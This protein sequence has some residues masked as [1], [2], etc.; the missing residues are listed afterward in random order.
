MSDAHTQSS[1]CCG[2]VPVCRAALG[3]ALLL[4]VV[5]FAY[6][7]HRPEPLG[8]GVRTNEQRE[9]NLRKLREHEAVANGPAVWIDKDKGVV[10]L[11]IARAMQLTVDELNAA[12]K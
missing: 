3:C 7:K 5:W 6:V 11:P 1:S 4:G 12:K 10:R 9:T 8:D 2:G